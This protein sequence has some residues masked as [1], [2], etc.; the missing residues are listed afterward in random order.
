MSKISCVVGVLEA[1][2]RVLKSIS[3]DSDG[4]CGRRP[5]A[6]VQDIDK[7][8]ICD[9]TLDDLMEPTMSENG[10]SSRSMYVSYS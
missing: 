10:T 1:C 4:S 5:P 8:L 9:V 7:Y 2:D 3:A 6:C